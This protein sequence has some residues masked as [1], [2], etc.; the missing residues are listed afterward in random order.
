MCV[1]NSLFFNGSFFIG[2]NSVPIWRLLFELH[3]FSFCIYGLIF[4]SKILVS[5]TAPS[6][7]VRLGMCRENRP[8]PPRCALLSHKVSSSAAQWYAGHTHRW[9]TSTDARDTETLSMELEGM[10][11][12]IVSSMLV[13]NSQLIQLSKRA[14]VIEMRQSNLASFTSAT[15][16]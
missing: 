6:R 5:D 8:G 2:E 10:N 15:R 12:L 11:W 1:A 7:K 16:L 3:F 14:I 13:M 4:H 9:R